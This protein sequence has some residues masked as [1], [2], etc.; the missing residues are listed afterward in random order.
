[1]HLTQQFTRWPQYQLRRQL[2]PK[3]SNTNAASYRSIQQGAHFG[4]RHDDAISNVTQLRSNFSSSSDN[5]RSNSGGQKTVLILGSSG[6]LGSTVASHL[7]QN[8]NCLTIGADIT[9]PNPSSPL[10][11]F[12]LLSPTDT[13]STLQSGIQSLHTD[14][15][16]LQLD[17]IICTNGGFTLDDPTN[18]S[19]THQQMMTLN[20][21]PVVAAAALLPRYMTTHQGLFLAMGASAALAPSAPTHTAYGASKAAVHHY[22]HS[23]GVMTGLG[24]G[25]SRAIKKSSE[26]LKRIQANEYLDSLTVLGLLPHVLDTEVN[27]EA[28]P[29]VD[30]RLWT[31]PMDLAREIGRWVSRPEFRPHSGS[32]VKALT[33]RV[34]GEDGDG[35]KTEFHLVR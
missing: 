28:M 20:Y 30:G 26:E 2:L 23:L 14:T 31:K 7:K 29:D 19:L 9:A 22:L 21:H 4:H 34:K 11:A 10:D 33:R 27:R 18:P 5:N 13:T 12:L 1:M 24:L 3:R 15:T 6:T 16:D 25:G 8:H 32:L 35:C 17:A